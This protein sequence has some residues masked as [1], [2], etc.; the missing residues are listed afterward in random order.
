M[1]PRENNNHEMRDD[2]IMKD[3]D[4][5][6]RGLLEMQAEGRQNQGRLEAS[7]ASLNDLI[8]QR[9]TAVDARVAEMS[10]VMRE[11]DRQADE[12]MKLMADTKQRRDIDANVRMADL[13]T[14]IQ[15]LTLGVKAIVS[16]TAAAQKQ[17][18]P[19]APQKYQQ[20]AMPSTSA[21]PQPTYRTVAQ[22]TAEQIRPSKLAPPATYKRD[23]TKLTKI[24]K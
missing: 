8:K 2:A 6:R 12:R 5:M 13:M 15:D 23:Q 7:M 11:R 14:T 21:A 9:E 1:Q 16:Q 19:R 17:A 4:E 20:V 10:A 22:P 18:A 3:M 24:A